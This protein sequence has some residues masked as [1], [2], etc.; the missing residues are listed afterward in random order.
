M[1]VSRRVALAGAAAA[2]SGFGA[3]RVAGATTTMELLAEAEIDHEHACFHAEYDDR[4]PL[5]AADSPDGP[6]ESDTHVIWEVTV[7]GTTGYV[8]FDAG[9]HFHGGPFVFY[10]AAGGVTPVTGVLVEQGSVSDADCPYLDGYTVV[11]PVD[12]TITLELSP[13]AAPDPASF[14]VSLDPP[15]TV[16]A[17]ADA[18]VGYTVENTGGL[19]DTQAVTMSVDG[20]VVD[21]ADLTLDPG[22][23]VTDEFTHAT[24]A[25]DSPELTVTVASADTERSATV[26]VVTPSLVLDAVD[27]PGAVAAGETATVTVTVENTGETAATETL[28][29]SADDAVVD[30]ADLTVEPGERVTDELAYATDEA[31]APAVSLGVAG[32]GKTVTEELSVTGAAPA[33]FAVELLSYPLSVTPGDTIVVVYRVANVGDEAGSEELTF[34]VDGE[35]ESTRTV[36]L[37]AGAETVEEFA[38]ATTAEDT[39]DREVAVQGENASGSAV[40]TVEEP[41]PAAVAVDGPDEVTVDPGAA[42]D[43]SVTVTNTGDTET[44]REVGLELDDRVVAT[45]SVSLAGG[46]TETVSFEGVEP[47]APGEYEAV[48]DGGDTAVTVPVVVSDPVTELAVSVG[49]EPV[50][51]ETADVEVTATRV[52]GATGDVTDE[53]TL[54]APDG[55]VVDGGVVEAV[56]PGTVELTASF[57]GLTATTAVTVARPATFAVDVRAEAQTVTAG[58]AVDLPVA[59][60]N[61]GDRAGEATVTVEGDG[62]DTVTRTATLDPGAE[63]TLTVSLDTT[64][65][66]GASTVTADTG[67]DTD[68]VVVTVETDDGNNGENGDQEGDGSGDDDMNGDGSGD[69]NGDGSDDADDDGSGFGVLAG[70][71]GLGGL[72]HLLRRAATDD[73]DNR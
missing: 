4:T 19:T 61:T 33:E 65:L 54:T 68:D 5:S 29:L 55:L 9:S 31:D 44:S 16:E 30:S 32:P 73:T 49:D 17:G 63:T 39:S 35:A 70:L 46:A 41:D 72:A 28:T 47:P 15:A 34:L 26:E 48:V 64:G 20:T 22:E 12:G 67:D 25:D 40:V 2:L 69:E 71:G 14:D 21:S 58:T 13:D 23:S 52:S 43:L 59:V 8:T 27:W 36:E 1:H 37:E 24:D 57:D 3:G 56:D 6:V 51:G 38:H 50:P 62:F 45:E 10:T 11:D 66:D 7:P 60:H 42:F 18:A 53:A